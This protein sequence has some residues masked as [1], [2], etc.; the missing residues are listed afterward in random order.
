[1]RLPTP[2]SS[3]HLSLYI[4][5]LLLSTLLITHTT[6][7]PSFTTT[8]TTTLT[9]TL[10]PRSPPST[11]GTLTLANGWHIH[12]AILTLITPHLPA[13]LHLRTFYNRILSE[14]L[15][16]IANNELAVAVLEVSMG[17]FT[18]SFKAEG[19]GDGGGGNSFLDVVDWELVFEFVEKL[20][21]GQVPATF[22]CR[23][24]PPG[25]AAAG[26]G[27]LIRLWTGVY[28]VANGGLDGPS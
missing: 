6:A 10:I 23:V 11:T 13:L 9:T 27:V 28:K 8:T 1:M 7:S 17:Q 2:S 21:E 3:L 24:T 5:L 18:L 14:T 26:R 15:N 12:Y 19:G 4:S 25:A 22:A 16:R 20:L